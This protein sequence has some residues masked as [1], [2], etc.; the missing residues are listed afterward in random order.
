MK[1][2]Y[3]HIILSR[4][5]TLIHREGL[6]TRLPITCT[7]YSPTFTHLPPF[8]HSPN[9][10]KLLDSSLL[11]LLL[12]PSPR[13]SLPLPPPPP[14]PSLQPNPFTDFVYWY[15]HICLHDV[16]V[17]W[18]AGYH[19]CGGFVWVPEDC[20]LPPAGTVGYTIQ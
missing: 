3:V 8:F 12:S 18:Y 5:Q 19:L 13:F 6:G 1:T 2:R 4:S 16:D 9:S 15:L 20:I 17:L 11:P 10:P 7:S 14:P